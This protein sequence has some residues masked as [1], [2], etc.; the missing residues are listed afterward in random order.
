MAQSIGNSPYQTQ[1][2]SPTDTA[3]IVAAFNN[4]HYGQSTATVT[5]GANS[6]EGWLAAKAALAGAAFTGNVSTTGTLSATGNLSTSA[7]LSVTGTTALTGNTT[8]GGSVTVTGTVVSHVTTNAQSASYTLVLSDDGKVIE[9]NNSLANTVTIPLNA[10][11]AF[12]IGTVITILQTGVGQTT[13]VGASGVTLNGSPGTKLRAQW[14]SGQ[15]LKRA[16]DT[17][18]ILGDLA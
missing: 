2:P 5:P 3:D 10:T 15:L 12:P 6:V 18:V 16:T 7:N 1:I 4:Y 14:S 9:V 11:V 17:W 8:I 13:I